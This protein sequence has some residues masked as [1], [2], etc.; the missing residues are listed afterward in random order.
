MHRPLLWRSSGLMR[1]EQGIDMI[2]SSI[3]VTR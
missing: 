1:G 2:V 3:E